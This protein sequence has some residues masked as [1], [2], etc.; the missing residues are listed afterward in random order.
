VPIQVVTSADL[1]AYLDPSA[2]ADVDDVHIPYAI[3]AGSEAN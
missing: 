1:E 3:E 2:G